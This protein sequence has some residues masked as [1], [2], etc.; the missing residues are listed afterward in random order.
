MAESNILQNNSKKNIIIFLLKWL[1]VSAFI[2]LLLPPMKKSLLA[3][4][5]LIILSFAH[6][7]ANR[8][9]SSAELSIP[10]RNY[11]IFALII[12]V[13]LIFQ[14]YYR[15]Q[16]LGVIHRFSE[17]IGIGSAKLLAIISLAL[18]IV[19][20]PAIALLTRHL[21]ENIFEVHEDTFYKLKWAIKPFLIFSLIYLGATITIVRANYNY[22]DDIGRAFSGYAG[23]DN[24]SRY[25]SNYLSNYIHANIYLADISPIPQLFT[26]VIL[27]ASS[28]IVLFVVTKK[29]QYH[30][31]DY[32][33]VLP[34]GLSPYFLECLSYKYDSP[35]MAISILAS[36]FPAVFL[37]D[38]QNG[39]KLFTA[40]FLGT[41]VV[42]MTYQAASGIFPML[43]VFV[44]G[45]KL[46]ERKES[47]LEVVSA[48]GLSAFGYIMAILLFKFFIMLPVDDYASNSIP[49]FDEL[50]PTVFANYSKYFQLVR[51]DFNAIW[52]LLVLFIV[53]SFILTVVVSNKENRLLNLTIALA[54]VVLSAALMFG[55]Y[56]FLS[57]TIFAPRAM[58]GF[59]AWIAFIGVATVAVIGN[60]KQYF[61]SKLFIFALAW[62]F[63]TFSFT[64]GNALNSQKQYTEYRT[65]DVLYAIN[66]IYTDAET[67]ELHITGSIGHA[68]AIR[69]TIAQYPILG[70]S[71]P[72]TLC[73]PGYVWGGKEIC[74]YYSI[75]L[76]L[77]ISDD[78]DAEL[79]VLTETCNYTIKGDRT[80]IVVDLKWY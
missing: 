23:W 33:A 5:L 26:V 37:M 59:G 39:K 63:F 62:S 22:I 12:I 8:N 77:N 66:K 44:C 3:A 18:G 14:F 48:I 24:F 4:V 55:L 76:T 38:A 41:L 78:F 67:H 21:L 68:P 56:P 70:R 9:K 45:L 19:A 58:Y 79:P 30:F 31:I 16:Y 2:V 25:I 80:R 75:P 29:K 7:F 57:A 65:Q 36:V 71:V 47:H 69:N 42:C 13:G 60:R 52:T 50:I 53:L 43:V 10:S 73:G 34:L 32:C 51:E 64:Y 40:S 35:Y 20:I 49:R 72:V 17:I 74:D 27:A 46:L 1:S 6:F 15:F 54:I 61:L 28:V 11:I